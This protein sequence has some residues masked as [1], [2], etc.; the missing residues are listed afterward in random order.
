MITDLG[1]MVLA[2][3]PE[4]GIIILVGIILVMDL[5]LRPREGRSVMGWTSAI[6]LLLIAVLSMFFLIPVTKPR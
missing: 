1:S 2:I 4:I 5:F 3:L 6:G